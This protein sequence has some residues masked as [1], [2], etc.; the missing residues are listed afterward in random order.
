[1][2]YE[3]NKYNISIINSQSL[4][5]P[6]CLCIEQEVN[7]LTILTADPVNIVKTKKNYTTTRVLYSGF[8]YRETQES[9]EKIKAHSKIQ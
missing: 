6:V 4:F 2:V 1:M 8:K 3:I 7:N 9:R 5:F